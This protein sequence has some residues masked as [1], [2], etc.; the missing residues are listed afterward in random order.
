MGSA[1]KSEGSKTCC[2]NSSSVW[3]PR[4][5]LSTTLSFHR[6][7]FVRTTRVRVVLGTGGGG[8]HSR[9][10]KTLTG[11]M[12]QRPS[13]RLT[14]PRHHM[15]GCRVSCRWLWTTRPL[16]HCFDRLHESTDALAYAAQ[17][18]VLAAGLMLSGGVDRRLRGILAGFNLM[19]VLTND[20]N[21]DR[22]EHHARFR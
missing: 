13:Q 22:N 7:L 9:N 8:L 4:G 3:L 12:G 20:W 6:K 15:E 21:D 18:I 14:I 10:N 1:V 16:S 19:T 17:H 2:A 5:K 11:T